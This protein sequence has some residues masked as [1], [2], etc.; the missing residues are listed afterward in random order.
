MKHNIF[1][2][3]G[4]TATN[5]GGIFDCYSAATVCAKHPISGLCAENTGHICTSM[6]RGKLRS[7]S[8]PKSGLCGQQKGSL[9]N[10]FF[11]RGKN[12]EDKDSYTDFDLSYLKSDFMHDKLPDVVSNWNMAETWSCKDGLFQLYNCQTTLLT[13]YE[14]IIEISS[15]EDLKKLSADVNSGNTSLSTL[16]RLTKDIDLGGMDWT[17][18]GSDPYKPFNVMFDGAGHTIQNFRVNAKKHPYAGLFG[19][20]ATN[21]YIVNLT[22]DCILS[23]QGNCAGP[24]CAQNYGYIHNCIA[25]AQTC[26][27]RYTGGFVGQNM[28]TITNCCALGSVLYPILFPWWLPLL[29]LTLLASL[30]SATFFFSAQNTPPQE[31]FAP[32]IIDPNAIPIEKDPFTPEEE[33]ITETNATF[34]MNAEM[35]VSSSNYAGTIGLRCPTWSKRGFVATVRVT[36][37]DLRTNGINVTGDYYTVYQ[38]GLIQPGYGVDVITL[39]ALP[40]GTKLPVGSYE[41]SVLFDF[42]DMETNERSTLDSI[43]PLDVIIH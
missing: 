23:G 3:A 19:C 6:F 13:N 5:S 31:I 7:S 27:C 42:Y 11:I 20:V 35:S 41:L 21:S 26:I 25:R 8:N 24:I 38:S 9:E 36:G 18:I 30:L 39:S 17:P 29:G 43:V 16:Y 40:D 32:V 28:G 10:S 2:V 12:E 4:F 33:K 1:L 15:R 37:A 34:I 14:R 22:V